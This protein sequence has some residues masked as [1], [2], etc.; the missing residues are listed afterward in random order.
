[1]HSSA[2]A[3]KYTCDFY[4][5]DNH[6]EGARTP[7]TMDSSSSPSHSGSCEYL[8]PGDGVK[9]MCQV[10]TAVPDPATSAAPFDASGCGFADPNTS[11]VTMFNNMPTESGGGASRG[12]F[13]AHAKL[14]KYKALSVIGVTNGLTKGGDSF[15]TGF[16]VRGHFVVVE[17]RP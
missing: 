10:I 6:G 1:M 5:F 7:C 3:G 14:P 11:A 2:F 15:G 12:S 4:T 9:G 16:D 8:F 13:A 17:C